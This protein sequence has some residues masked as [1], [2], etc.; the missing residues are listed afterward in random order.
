VLLYRYRTCVLYLSYRTIVLLSSKFL[1]K[2]VFHESRQD[3]CQQYKDRDV[4]FAD[5]SIFEC[6]EYRIRST[7]SYK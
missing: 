1:N 5:E 4:C 6:S 7:S 2:G 3:I